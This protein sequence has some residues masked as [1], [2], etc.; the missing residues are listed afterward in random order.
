MKVPRSNQYPTRMTSRSGLVPALYLNLSVETNCCDREMRAHPKFGS[1]CSYD[2]KVVIWKEEKAPGALV[3][4]GLLVPVQKLVSGGC[5]NI[6]KDFQNSTIA[7]AS[8]DG[9]VI[10]WTVA[11][12]GDHQ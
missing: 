3:G 9:T 5:D 11:E 7:S 10:I 6:L 4:S 2:G 1:S 8:Q 12:E